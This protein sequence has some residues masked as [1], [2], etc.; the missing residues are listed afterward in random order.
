[1]PK[2]Y[3]FQEDSKAGCVLHVILILHLCCLVLDFI[4]LSEKEK[5]PKNNFKNFLA[6][7]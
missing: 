1:M 7:A 2:A 6:I 4:F 3:I 5:Q